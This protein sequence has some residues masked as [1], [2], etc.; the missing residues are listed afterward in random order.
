[1]AAAG[2]ALGSGAYE[3]P[4]TL[5]ARVED[6]ERSTNPE[7]LIGAAH[8]GCFTMSLANLLSESGHPPADLQHDREGPPR[9]A[10]H[11]VRDH[12]HRPARRSARCRA[13][14]P[15]RSRRSP[16]RPRTPARCRAR[17]PARRSRWRQGLPAT[18]P[19]RSAGRTGQAEQAVVRVKDGVLEQTVIDRPGRITRATGEAEEVLFVL[20]GTGELS[21]AGDRYALEPET[22]ANL[23]PGEEYELAR[24][25]SASGA[26]ARRCRC[27]ISRSGRAD[28]RRTHGA[29]DDAR[30]RGPPAGR[31]GGAGRHHRAH[32]PDRRGPEH[33]PA[34]GDPLRRLHPDR[35]GARALPHLRRSHLHARGRGRAARRR[36]S[37]TPVGAGSCIELP[38]RTVHCLENTGEDVMRLVAVFRPAGSPAAAYYPDGTPAYPGA[39]PLDRI[40]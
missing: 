1:M 8:A 3:G 6:V 40:K 10:R 24:I 15:R 32:V 11:R 17:S 25:R 21:L 20:Q 22:G 14:T 5:R 16:S 36:A 26:D 2:L 31:P 28:G 12:Q 4:F 34:V 9:A 37:R 13:S 23:A 39:P 27:G 19:G 18:D 35:A 7:E 38:A 33:R 30:G 29:T